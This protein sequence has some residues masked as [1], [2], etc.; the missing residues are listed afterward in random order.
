MEKAVLKTLIYSDIFDYPLRVYEI[1][2]WLIGR[3]APLRRV[4][5][6]L[7]HLSE[8]R[9]AKSE[10]RYYSLSRKEGL[11]AKRIK[12]ANQSLVY[13]RKVRIIAH[14]LKIIPWIKLVGISGGL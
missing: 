13:I 10:K 2:K 14:I 1:H 6:V 11:A 5:T 9:K 4:E 7:K 3:Q 8:N 12:R